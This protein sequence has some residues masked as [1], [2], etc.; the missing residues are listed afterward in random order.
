MRAAILALVLLTGACGGSPSTATEST[1]TIAGETPGDV[2]DA[3]LRDLRAVVAAL[4]PGMSRAEVTVSLGSRLDRLAVTSTGPS[5]EST[6]VYALG[7]SNVLWLTW[8]TSDES[9]IWLR[10]A[11]L[12]NQDRDPMPPPLPYPPEPRPV[13]D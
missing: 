2:G 9:D 8:D 4:R 5:T 11:V 13:S 6:Q 7:R 3:E 1:E 12:W 10:R